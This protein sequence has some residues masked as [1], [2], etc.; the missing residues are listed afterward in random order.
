MRVHASAGPCSLAAGPTH[1][2]SGMCFYHH[3]SAARSPPMVAQLTSVADFGRPRPRLA[4]AAQYASLQ[5]AEGPLQRQAGDLVRGAVDQALQ[6]PPQLQ[7]RHLVHPQQQQQ[8]RHLGEEDGEQRRRPH[9]LVQ[10]PQLPLR[11]H[12]P[13]EGSGNHHQQ[14]QQQQQERQPPLALTAAEAEAVT[15]SVLAAFLSSVEES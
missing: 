6:K 15:H 5:A 12:L 13:P 3:Q 11:H 14:P 8:R 7:Q 2:A 10:Q 1:P 4:A 9:H